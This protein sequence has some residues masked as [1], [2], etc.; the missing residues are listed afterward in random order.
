MYGMGTSSEMTEDAILV[1]QNVLVKEFLRYQKQIKT[2]DLDLG[3]LNKVN[4]SE[5]FDPCRVYKNLFNFDENLSRKISLNFSAL[6]A[7]LKNFFATIYYWLNT[8]DSSQSSEFE[9]IKNENCVRAFLVAL[10]KICL[11]DKCFFKLKNLPTSSFSQNP[12]SLCQY[13]QNYEK[14]SLLSRHFSPREDEASSEFL[15]SLSDD[16]VKNEGDHQYLSQIRVK[17]NSFSYSIVI[18]NY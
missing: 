3:D 6:S 2:F 4:L 16:L 1:E 11:I 15:N 8:D 17:L 7:R 14:D 10:I 5:L 9:L 12:A 18:N 13:E